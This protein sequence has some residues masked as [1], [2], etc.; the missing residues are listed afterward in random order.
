MINI[1]ENDA[2]VLW[3]DMLGYKRWLQRQN[4]LETAEKTLLN[5]LSITFQG[6]RGGSSPLPDF[7]IRSMLISDTIVFWSYKIDFET[8][9][10]LGVLYHILCTELAHIGLTLRGALAKGSLRVRDQDPRIILGDSII[11]CA[12]LERQLDAFV[13]ALDDS[14]IQFILQAPDSTKDKEAYV[15]SLFKTRIVTKNGG[16][17][18]IVLK[19]MIA[20]VPDGIVRVYRRL[21]ELKE[22]GDTNAVD[23]LKL[24]ATKF[25]N[26]EQMF[27]TI[28][29]DEFY[30]MVSDRWRA[31]VKEVRDCEPKTRYIQF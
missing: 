3:L 25:L 6:L 24:F 18:M 20:T 8:L 28:M 5:A 16:D 21:K 9:L 27:A 17:I 7:Q 10:S 12:T 30:E 29:K 15:G 22:A 19:W 11:R 14:I 2:F 31:T 26:S 4:D 23:E 1:I 13:V